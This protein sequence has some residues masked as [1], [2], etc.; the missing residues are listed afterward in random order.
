MHILLIEDN[1]GDVRLTQEAF[2][3]ANPHTHVEL[4]VVPDGEEALLCLR[5]V[6]RYQDFS[7]PDL[8]FLDLNIPKRDG[9]EV[10][11]EIKSDPELL[12]IPV[13]V[14]TTS[15]AEADIRKTYAL[16]ANCYIT[17]P[18]DMNQFIEVVRT[19]D[20]FWFKTAKLPPKNNHLK[21][22]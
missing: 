15:E 10:L 22:G 9:K 16:H 5:R 6:G 11:Q 19:I 20:Q 4:T 17:K 21:K 14:L 12:M 1:P 13:L 7:L 8:I 18:V 3:E 2:K